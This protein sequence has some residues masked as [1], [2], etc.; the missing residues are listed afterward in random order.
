MNNCTECDSV[1][2]IELCGACNTPLC[3]KH[4]VELGSLSDGYACSKAGMTCIGKLFL[5][6]TEPQPVRILPWVKVRPLGAR[7]FQATT[8]FVAGI[9]VWLVALALDLYS[10]WG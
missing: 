1:E 10:Y 8:Y 4:R 5:G 7:R 3:P 9:I 6:Q 2:S